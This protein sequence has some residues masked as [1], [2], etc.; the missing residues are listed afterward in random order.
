MH[1]IQCIE[2][3]IIGSPANCLADKFTLVCALEI[4]ILHLWIHALTFLL[5]IASHLRA[6]HLK[7]TETADIKPDC[8]RALREI[9][10]VRFILVHMR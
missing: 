8:D 3:M 5:K 10:Q 9:Q 6:G 4:C 1:R 2:Y 7:Y